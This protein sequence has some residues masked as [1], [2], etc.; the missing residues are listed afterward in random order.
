MPAILEKGLRLPN[1]MDVTHS[2]NLSLRHGVGAARIFASLRYCRAR[3]HSSDAGVAGRGRF[4]RG[5]VFCCLALPGPG[6]APVDHGGSTY[7]FF[8]GAQL[9]PCYMPC[10]EHDARFLSKLAWQAWQAPSEIAFR[11]GLLA[12]L[13]R[14]KLTVTTD[15]TPLS[16]R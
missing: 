6:A 12:H 8:D 1:G 13:A 16:Q 5:P 3:L 7:V 10:S 4:S 11:A 15:S 2:T 9:L 14:T